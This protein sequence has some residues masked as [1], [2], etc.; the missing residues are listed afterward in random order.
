MNIESLQKLNNNMEYEE[1]KSLLSNNL[2]E[3]EFVKRT[4]NERRV[5]M[6]TNCKK[7]LNSTIGEDEFGY[8][9]VSFTGTGMKYSPKSK[10]TI[11]VWDIVK[12][13]WRS[14]PVDTV[15][16]K[17]IYKPEEVFDMDWDKILA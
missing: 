9:N 12:K 4:N 1:L 8:K 6:C 2:L 13:G 10:N 11:I 15:E 17:N 14:I 7:I 5:M 16:V 3:V